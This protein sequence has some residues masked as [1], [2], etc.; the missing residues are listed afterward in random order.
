MKERHVVRILISKGKVC[1]DSLVAILGWEDV[2]KM[3]SVNE[4]IVHCQNQIKKEPTR[5]R[6]S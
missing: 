5:D 6:V 3:A 1:S 4:I 2:V